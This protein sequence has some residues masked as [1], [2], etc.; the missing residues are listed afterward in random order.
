MSPVKTIQPLS[1]Y[2]PIGTLYSILT[3]VSRYIPRREK[4]TPL[5]KIST[6]K[7]ERDYYGS[8]YD[9]IDTIL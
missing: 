2:Y 9:E 1:F 7:I 5:F 3:C 6:L 4:A 8:P